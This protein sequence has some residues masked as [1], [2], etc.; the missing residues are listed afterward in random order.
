MSNLYLKKSLGQHFLKDEN[1]LQQIAEAI[2]D[3][4]SVVLDKWLTLHPIIVPN[5]LVELVLHRS[6]VDMTVRLQARS[7][8]GDSP[9]TSFRI[10]W[11]GRWTD[12]DS[13]MAQHLVIR[14]TRW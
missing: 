10:A 12:G 11:D 13:E 6:A 1:V 5:N 4:C 9:I 14:P 3:L 8:D 2:G 7:N